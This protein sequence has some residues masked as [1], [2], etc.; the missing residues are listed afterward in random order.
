[1]NELDMN[2]DEVIKIVELRKNNAFRK[3]NEEIIKMYWD[4]GEYVSNR[5]ARGEWGEK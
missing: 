1:M 5:L 2:F 3:V 4:F